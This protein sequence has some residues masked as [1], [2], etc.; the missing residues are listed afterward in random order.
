MSSN[1]PVIAA[2]GRS[3]SRA[4]MGRFGIAALGTILAGSSAPTPLYRLY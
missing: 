2:T 3:F 4:A 1:N